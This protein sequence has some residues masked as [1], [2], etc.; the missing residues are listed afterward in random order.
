MSEFTKV[1][2]PVD[3]G[4]RTHQHLRMNAENNLDP[5]AKE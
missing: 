4:L 3:A 1:S 2:G 5:V